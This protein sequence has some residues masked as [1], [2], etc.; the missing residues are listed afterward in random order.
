MAD[1]AAA[2]EVS[3]P[4]LFKYFRSKEDLVLHRILDHRAEAARVVRQRR[5]D[6]APLTAL[7]RHFLAGL[8]RR[9]PVTGLNDHPEVLAYHAMVF[10]TPSLA[11]RVARYAADDEEALAEALS[12]AAPATGVLDARLAAGQVV[13][14]QRILARENW[15]QLSAGRT[16][17]EVYPEAVAAVDS[18]F[19]LLATGLTAYADPGGADT[20]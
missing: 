4:T 1:V 7:H 2:A 12:E 18:A 17:A 9:D 15:Q 8:D 20:D 11:A 13:A 10:G 14:V 16:A 19:R 5:A 3:K 6:E